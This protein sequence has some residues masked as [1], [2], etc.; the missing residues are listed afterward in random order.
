MPPRGITGDVLIA[1]ALVVL[2]LLALSGMLALASRAEDSLERA[3]VA[4]PAEEKAAA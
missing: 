2:S 1:V 4:E 3:L